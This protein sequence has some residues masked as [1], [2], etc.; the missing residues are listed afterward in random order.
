METFVFRQSSNIKSATYDPAKR[1]LTIDYHHGR[2]YPAI[3]N[4]SPFTWRQ[5]KLSDSPGAF[6]N[7]NFRR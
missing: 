1:Q 5:F 6:V 3:Q 2:S 7:K 4:V